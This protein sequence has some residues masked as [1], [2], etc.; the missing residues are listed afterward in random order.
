MTASNGADTAETVLEGTPPVFGKASPALCFQL[1]ACN[2]TSRAGSLHLP[3][4]VVRTPVFMPVGTKGTIKGLLS[5]Q[6]LHPALRPEVRLP[7]DYECDEI[8]C[9]MDFTYQLLLAS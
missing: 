8:V 9:L 3:H 6:L 4:G 1:H 5:S 7:A 2:A